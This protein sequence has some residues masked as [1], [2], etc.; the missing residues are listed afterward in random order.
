MFVLYFILSLIVLCITLLCF[1][2]KKDE[3]SNDNNGITSYLEI[4]QHYNQ[5]IVRLHQLLLIYHDKILEEVISVL[6]ETPEKLTKLS[7]QQLPTLHNIYN[8]FSNIDS[9]YISIFY[10]GTIVIN[11]DSKSKLTRRYCYGLKVEEN[12]VGLK[13]A[14]LDVKWS[15][16]LGF[17]WNSNISH[18]IWNHTFQ[19]RIIIM[20]DI[21][22]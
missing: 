8:L 16:K 7:L 11:N 14:N 9:I 21:I 2:R 10:P 22:A 19:P 1:W 3:H 15:H 6:D 12:D 5:D 13:I 17:T 4:D 18:S 20:A